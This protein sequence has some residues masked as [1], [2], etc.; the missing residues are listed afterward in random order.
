M[1]GRIEDTI[2]SG[3]TRRALQQ[4]WQEYLMEAAGLGL[5]MISAGSF[6]TLLEHPDSAVRQALADPLARRILMGIA[7]G[8]TAIGLIY[9]PWGKQ[10]GAHFNPAVTLTFLRL[11]KV[12]KPDALFYAAAQFVGA[13]AGILLV[14]AA[15]NPLL[16]DPAVNYVA[17]VPGSRGPWVAFFAELGISFLLMTVV[18]AVS[19][20][21]ALPQYTGVSAGFLVASYIAFEAPLSGMSMNPGRTFGSALAADLWTGIWIYFTA[22]PLGMLLASE[23]YRSRKGLAAIRCAKL[24]HQN[25][26]RCI[27]RCGYALTEIRRRT[28]DSESRETADERGTASGRIPAEESSLEALGALPQR[29]PV[30]HR[31]R[32]L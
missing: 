11:G 1:N 21:Q 4:H 31:A 23:V 24:H 32:G 18:L 15:F 2:V 22:P 28:H 12:A 13:I 14:G 17:T 20:S 6:A 30:G 26:K 8:L 5:F 25:N 7:M 29:A 10:S 19:N 16:G 9:S 27:F 3:E